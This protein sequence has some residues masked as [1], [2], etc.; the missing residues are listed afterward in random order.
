MRRTDFPADLNG[1]VLT[2]YGLFFVLAAKQ[3]CRSLQTTEF[4]MARVNSRFNGREGAILGRFGRDGKNRCCGW[5]D[6]AAIRKIQISVFI[7]HD[8]ADLN[9]P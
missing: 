8:D 4:R 3:S 6:Q 1:Y 7:S 9:L 5:N 2:R